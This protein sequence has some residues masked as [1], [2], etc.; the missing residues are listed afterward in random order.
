MTL[1]VILLLSAATAWGDFYV[2]PTGTPAGDGTYENPRDLQTALDHPAAVKPGDTIWLRGGTYGNGGATV[3]TCRLNGTESAPIALRA[4]PGERA[5]IDGG[6]RAESGCSW[7][8]F[9][10]LEITNSSTVRECG[11]SDR[12]PGI[13]MTSRGHKAINCIIHDVGHPGIGFWSP[14]GDGGEIHGTLFWA[15]GLYDTVTP[16]G[17]PDNPWTRGSAI[18]TQNADGTRYIREVIC[19]RSFTIG[20]KPYTEGGRIEGYHVEGN[21]SFDNNDWNIYYGDVNGNVRSGGYKLLSNCTYR[22]PDD[23]TRSV[24]VGYKTDYEDAVIQDNYF[25]A[26]PLSNDTG[27]MFVRK[28]VTLNVTGNTLVGPTLLAQWRVGPATTTTW[29]NNHYYGG[30][31]TPFRVDDE[32]LYD[33]AGWKTRTGF[34]AGSTHSPDFPQGAAVF[35]R[36]NGYENG[37]GHVIVYNWDETAAVDVDL[38]PIINNGDSFEVRDTQNYYA[39]PVVAGVFDGNPIAMPMDLTE[40]AQPVGDCPHIAGRFTHTAPRFAA[41]VVLRTGPATVRVE[42]NDPTGAEPGDDTAS[43]RVW[44]T[45]DTGQPLTVH[46]TVGGSADPGFDY[47][48]LAGSVTIPPGARFAEITV[49]PLDDLEEDPGETV[50][51][52]LTAG[53]GCH[54]DRNRSATIV[55]RDNDRLADGLLGWWKLDDG[56]GTVACDSSGTSNHGSVV[57]GTWTTDGRIDGAMTFDGTDDYVLTRPVV[58][59][60]AQYTV[61]TWFRTTVEGACDI[62]SEGYSGSYLQMLRVMVNRHSAGQIGFEHRPD[63][64]GLDMA[65]KY[66]DVDGNDGEWHFVAVVREG[67]SVFHLYFDGDLKGSDTTHTV[68]TTTVDRASIGALSMQ[69]IGAYFSGDIDDVRLYDRALAPDEVG[70]LH[71]RGLAEPHRLAIREGWSMVSIPVEPLEPEREIVFPP[72][73]VPEVWEYTEATGYAAPATV[74]V[75]KGYWIK[76]RKGRDLL[77]PGHRPAGT[78]VPVAAGWNLIGVVGPSPGQPWQ[79]VPAGPEILGIWYFVP[80]YRVPTGQ[81]DEDKGYWIRASEAATIWNE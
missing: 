39:A 7:T 14:V 66:A 52:T 26:G 67:A 21:V 2:S 74:A 3:F 55:F 63:T 37:R 23:A 45:G 51:V 36:P 11:P 22:R 32:A 20:I 70:L 65:R 43:F 48:P 49:T 62:Y 42:A 68:G 15:N 59:D 80:P 78:S 41:F 18:Y 30:H 24:R 75:K 29:D 38:S 19:F 61:T 28:W 77:I 4:F 69:S 27:V 76:A 58:A 71:Q 54:L 50:T 40:V 25:V 34:D 31:A 47:Q 13:N 44:R 12:P 6:I 81:C 8:W 16:P 53:A 5:T 10:G 9:W 46:Y 73:Y 57:G 35:V 17:T 60:L 72:N 33:F 79:P 1:A 64:G 56:S